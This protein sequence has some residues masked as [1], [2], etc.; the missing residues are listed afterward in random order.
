M[1]NQAIQSVIALLLLMSVGYYLDGKAWFSGQGPSIF[2]KFTVNVAMPCYMV[3]NMYTTV[4]SKDMLLTLFTALPIP[5]IGI[6]LMIA[7]GVLIAK[8]LH[9]DE[10]RF[11][12][13]VNVCGLS[14][15]VIIGFPVITS[16]LGNEAAPLGMIY[17]MANTLTFW[18]VGVYLLRHKAGEK[19]PFFSA[20]NL[21]KILSPPL[22]GFF[23]GLVIVLLDFK[24]PQFLFMPLEYLAR[25]TT[26]IALVFIG[27]VI[28]SCHWKELS[29]SR[30]LFALLGCRFLLGPVIM[31]I[32]CLLLPP[33]SP[34]RPV[35]LILSTMP[36]MTQLG[37]MSREL[38]S[39]YKFASIV[40]AI[41]TTMSM[42]FLPIY[43]AI[44]TLLGIF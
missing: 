35:F 17:Y 27:C 22:V 11:G 14:N 15:A 21:K 12:V 40:I 34:M 9:V 39:D 42:V 6:C 30:D 18:T 24:L 25:S 38:D 13:F 33:A 26:A 32:V 44:M 16:V 10:K 41:S 8:L 7:T 37:I 4:D 28:H 20:D 23:I 1:L 36:A 29:L 19:T 5:L 43:T 2:S 31:F 3:Y